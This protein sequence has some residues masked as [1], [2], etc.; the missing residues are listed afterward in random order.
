MNAD[1]L[2]EAYT[3]ALNNAVKAHTQL[4]AKSQADLAATIENAKT[5]L[6]SLVK[7][8][9]VIDEKPLPESAWVK[10]HLVLNKEAVE[11]FQGLFKAISDLVP[12]L[13]K[14]THK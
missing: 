12:E 13:K 10:D 8:A 4:V 1:Q 9:E 7:S 14:L 11:L 3:E 5:E 6:E 2:I